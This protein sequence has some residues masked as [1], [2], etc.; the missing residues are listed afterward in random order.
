MA[1]IR[2]DSDERGV[3]GPPGGSINAAIMRRTAWLD[4]VSGL[5]GLSS[6]SVMRETVSLLVEANA[7]G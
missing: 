1:P 2:R 3:V 6:W 7:R 4:D 5:P